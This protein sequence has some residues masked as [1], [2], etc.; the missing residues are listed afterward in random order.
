MNDEYDL[1]Q[2]SLI[3]KKT[4]KWYIAEHFEIWWKQFDS[5]L[6]NGACGTVEKPLYEMR[7]QSEKCVY[8]QYE[9]RLF[10]SVAEEVI[11]SR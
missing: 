9:S 10:F 4:L 5:P 7:T 6:Y 1:V 3:L 8:T 11:L 2:K